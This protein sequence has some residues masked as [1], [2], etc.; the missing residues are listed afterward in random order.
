MMKKLPFRVE[1]YEARVR[2]VKERMDAA[3]IEVLLVVTI[4]VILASLVVPR[5]AGLSKGAKL[6]AAKAQIDG[7][8]SVALDLYEL[9]NGS[10][11]STEQGLDALREEPTTDPAPPEWEKNI[12]TSPR[13]SSLP[14]ASN[15][16]PSRS[17][18]PL[19]PSWPLSNTSLSR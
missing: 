9:H 13:P 1:E 3:G 12:T 19:S 11:P 2:K 18:S 8:F 7:N 17:L 6:D 15:P 16:N 4:I 14:T 5:F 10:Y